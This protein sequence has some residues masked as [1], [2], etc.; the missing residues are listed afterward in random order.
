MTCPHPTSPFSSI[1][2]GPATSKYVGLTAEQISFLD[3]VLDSAS[4]SHVS[5]EVRSA[6]AKEA[7]ERW[8]RRAAADSDRATRLKT[9]SETSF[10]QASARARARQTAHERRTAK[11]RAEAA[12]AAAVSALTSSDAGTPAMTAG[13]KMALALSALPADARAR[14]E[15]TVASLRAQTAASAD[16]IITLDSRAFK[17][18]IGQTPRPFHT[19]VTVNAL[20]TQHRC[21]PCKRLHD[22]LSFSAKYFQS[23]PDSADGVPVF[24]VN[25][26]LA[27]SGDLVKQLGLQPPT[28]AVIPPM[29][30][31]PAQSPAELVSMARYRYAPTPKP[32]EADLATFVGRGTGFTVPTSTPG[33]GIPKGKIITGIAVLGA[34]ILGVYFFY[35]KLDF[36]RQFT[37]LYAILAW[38]GYIYGVSGGMF[39]TLNKTPFSTVARD[40]SPSYIAPG[41]MQQFGAES[42]IMAAANLA[43][44]LV[45]VVLSAYAFDKTSSAK[46]LGITQNVQT[47]AIAAEGAA[48]AASN[49]GKLSKAAEEAADP[50]ASTQLDDKLASAISYVTPTNMIG[51]VVVPLV[52]TA[53][54]FAGWRWIIAVYTWKN[55]GYRYGFVW[56]WSW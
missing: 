50:P 26:E 8:A 37:G 4:K 5:P 24:F 49:G 32:T 13:E 14:A 54:F 35:D 21:P 34:A 1:T 9:R 47:A 7:H 41:H 45:C 22:A 25:V 31:G 20:T 19:V 39:N 44:A 42:V 33:E 52:L 27:R 12:S 43:C 10:R 56:G 15:Q 29:L 17:E 40:G 38:I 11:W 55:K 30:T 51:R 36:F 53:L 18:A 6:Q 28:S 46:H 2:T 3:S 16:G 48:A 23:H